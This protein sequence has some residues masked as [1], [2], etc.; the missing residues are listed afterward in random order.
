MAKHAVTQTANYLLIRKTGV[1]SR[2]SKWE[3]A[4][5]DSVI[6]LKNQLSRTALKCFMI[7]HAYDCTRALVLPTVHWKGGERLPEAITQAIGAF[8]RSE[9]KIFWDH[10]L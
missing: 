7:I 3:V 4:R 9:Q 1:A 5:V 8:E 6:R 10:A 2:N